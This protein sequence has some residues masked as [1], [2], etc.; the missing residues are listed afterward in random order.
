MLRSLALLSSA[1]AFACLA[2][3]PAVLA[4]EPSPVA[5]A[6]APGYEQAFK[7]AYGA[8]EVPALSSQVARLVSRSLKSAG[9]RCSLPLAVTVERAVP[10]YPTVKQQMDDPTL[11]PFHTVTRD[12]G[13]SLTG[14]VLDPAGRVLATVKYQHFNGYQPGLSPARD[15][16]SQ[17][18]VAIDAFSRR[19]VSACT[20]QSS[21]A[22]S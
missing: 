22:R 19:L 6:F 8:A 20:Q 13:A 10:T 12:S 9:G 18:R 11:S 3:A 21:S 14:H 7:K 4:S 15:P 2:S 17:A 5:V 1:L 16:W